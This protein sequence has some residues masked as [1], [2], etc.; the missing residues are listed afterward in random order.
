MLLV[1]GIPMIGQFRTAL[2]GIGDA[3]L[4]YALKQELANKVT[5]EE[6]AAQAADGATIG[7]VTAEKEA[8]VISSIK[9]AAAKG[10][11]TLATLAEIGAQNS[12]TLA[13]VL[14]IAATEGLGVAFKAL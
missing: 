7:V 6:I 9:E 2:A 4:A 14:G 3:T 12:L 13:Q 8:L 10:D 5:E 11:V 1:M